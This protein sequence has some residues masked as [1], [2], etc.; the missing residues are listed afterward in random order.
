[1][2]FFLR[3][4]QKTRSHGHERLPAM[5]HP[6]FLDGIELGHGL[7]RNRIDLEQRVVSEASLAA[8]AKRNPPRTNALRGGQTLLGRGQDQDAA[9]PRSAIHDSL[10]LPKK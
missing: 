10:E 7:S 2:L 8:R 6:V 3:Q 4:P 9:K 1:M 5:A